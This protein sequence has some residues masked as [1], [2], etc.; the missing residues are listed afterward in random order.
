MKSAGRDWF[1]MLR[2][3][4][5]TSGVCTIASA[6]VCVA[7]LSSLTVAADL[8][9]VTDRIA[10]RDYPSVFQAW[11]QATAFAGK[12][13]PQMQALHDLVFL[14]PTA[15]GL[16]AVGPCEGESLEFTV[17]SLAAGLARRRELL[18][19]NPA[20]V[21]LAEIRYRDAPAGFLPDDSPWWKRAPD[22][23]FVMGWAEGGY[24][25]LD[26]GHAG[27]HEQVARRAKAVMETGCFDGIMLDWW[28]DDADRQ[29]LVRG[30]RRAVGPEALILVNSNDREI[31]RTAAEVN[32]LFME[33]YRSRDAGDWQRISRTL[34]WAERNLRTPRINCVESWH[35]HSRR[36]LSL[37]R[38]VTTLVLTHADGYCLFS[39]PNDLPTPD[40]LHDW[41]DFW[42]KGLG[43][44]VGPG[45]AVE[46][47]AWRRAFSQGE[48]V[49][50]P[51]G[52]REIELRF[53]TPHRSRATGRIGTS[54]VV[55]AWDGDIFIRP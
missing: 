53:E 54:H 43:R 31:P 41:Y 19:L 22:R 12:T 7:L 49:Y 16:R 45:R 15:M 17:D 40:H 18:R 27:W 4:R 50:N 33:C 25:L 10:A 37:M 55:K 34:L 36:D 38:A 6:A 23:G 32:G 51:S 1:V 5:G 13:Q 28:V 9:A 35:H 52:G 8:S 39:D 20:I 2:S 24:R 3:P 30:V 42:D 29:A 48:V 47:G 21:I 26:V 44:P 14:H 46:H 11:N